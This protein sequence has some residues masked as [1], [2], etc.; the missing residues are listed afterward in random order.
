MPKIIKILTFFPEIYDCLKFGVVGRAI[1]QKIMIELINLKHENH[2]DDRPCGG[3]GGMIVRADKIDKQIDSLYSP[4]IYLSPR[5]IKMNQS[6]FYE[7]SQKP[8][9]SIVCGRYEGI[10][11]RLIDHYKMIEISLGD[12]ILSNG[13]LAALVL[14]DGVI[15][16]IPNVIEAQSLLTESFENFLLEHNQYTQPIIWKNLEVPKALLCGDH[17]IIENFRLQESIEITKKNRPDLYEKYLE[18]SLK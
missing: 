7:L 2:I 12:F 13:D 6:L 11:Q 16:L 18:I 5:G 10:D 14:L 1:G 17:K 9:F 3:G 4:I 15:R 8:S